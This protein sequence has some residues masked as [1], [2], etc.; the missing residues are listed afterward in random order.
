MLCVGGP[1]DGRELEIDWPV[2]RVV[3]PSDLP[4]AV[5]G[6]ELYIPTKWHAMIGM[7]ADEF[8]G[9]PVPQYSTEWRLRH[10]SIELPE[11]EWE[12]E[13]EDD[14]DWAMDQ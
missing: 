8:T 2:T 7:T 13:D 9:Q 11:P 3:I 12:D 14:V 10:S 4:T 6:K 5:D 1:L